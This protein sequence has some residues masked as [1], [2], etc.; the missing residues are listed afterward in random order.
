[1]EFWKKIVESPPY[2]KLY[3]WL[4]KVKIAR[5][6]VSLLRV[7]EILYKKV[8][9]INIHQ[10]ASAIAFSFTLSL[11]PAILFLFSLIPYFA[12]YFNIP[13]LNSQILSELEK[14]IPPNIFEFIAPTI[15]D[16]IEHPRGDVLSFVF[17]LALYAASSGVVELMYTLNTNFHYSEKRSFIHRRMI[18]IVLSSLFAFL[19]VF[20]VLVMLV[21]QLVL[22]LLLQEGLLDANFLYYLLIILRY[23]IT[24]LVF[25]LSIAYIYYVGPASHKE[26]HFISLGAGIASFF[27]IIST[28]AFSYYLSHFATYN[29]LY[30][31]IGTIIALMLW[32]YVL[33]WILLLGF[34]LDASIHEGRIEAR[35]LKEQKYDLLKDV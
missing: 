7:V 11:F 22:H 8:T 20:V 21:G 2:Q 27:A 34:A 19:L 33:A 28:N 14:A 25:Y 30:G 31:S 32:F 16:I 9:E 23:V 3:Q 29:K 18:A 4:S 10:Q 26:W 1:M 24:F 5:K 15:S 17:I 6:Q 12:Y 35:K 13:D